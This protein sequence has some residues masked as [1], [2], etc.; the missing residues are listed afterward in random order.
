MC[1]LKRNRNRV[2]YLTLNAQNT[3]YVILMEKFSNVE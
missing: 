3:H 1:D 2:S